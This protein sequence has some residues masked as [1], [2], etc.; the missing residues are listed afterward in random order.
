MT[1]R[2]LL[3]LAVL[4]LPGSTLAD[5]AVILLYHH[6]STETPRSTSVTPERFEAH[7]QYLS[8]NEFQV[9][10]LDRLLDAVLDDSEPVPDNVVAITFDDAY[11]SVYREAW[12]R[13]A[14]RDWPFAVFVNTDA[15]DQGLDPYLSWDELRELAGAG[16]LIG[17]HSASH[18]HLL[19]RSDEESME[20]WAARVRADLERAR[21]RIA[22]EVGTDSGLFAYPYGEDAGE[23]HGIVRQLGYRGLTQRSGALG[24][25]TDPRAIPRF[26][27]ATGFDS[28]ERL[29]R[30]VHA[31]PLP[32]KSAKTRPARELGFVQ[33][34]EAVDLVIETGGFRPETLSCFSGAGDRLEMSLESGDDLSV[35]IDVAGR[36]QPGRN[37]VN[38]TAPSGDGSGAFHWFAFQWLQRHT[39]GRWPSR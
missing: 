10:P 29:A 30:A 19:H 27:M 8:E 26:P 1:G 17:N 22:G 35:S 31:R 32:V 37:R 39:D 4:W 16:V 20:Q 38:C 25:R 21:D 6:V 33:N 14:E 5:H 3:I 24:A 12:P 9:W 36:G 2:L 11:D 13:L 15:V 7:L 23:L 34:P 18:D 28:L